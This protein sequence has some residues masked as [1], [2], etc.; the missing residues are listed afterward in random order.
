MVIDLVLTGKTI[1]DIGHFEMS[2]EQKL[3]SQSCDEK[4]EPT[5]KCNAVALGGSK[6][7]LN[8]KIHSLF[9]TT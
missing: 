7:N 1:M 8:W 3:T 5:Y 2:N 9:L 6:K 4:I